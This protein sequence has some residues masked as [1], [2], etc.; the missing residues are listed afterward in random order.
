[1]RV[2]PRGRAREQLEQRGQGIREASER[3]GHQRAGHQRAGHQRGQWQQRAVSIQQTGGVLLDREGSLL[4]RGVPVTGI[5]QY[6]THPCSSECSSAWH[7][8]R[9]SQDKNNNKKTRD[10][11]TTG[12]PR[13]GPSAAAATSRQRK[14]RGKR[15]KPLPQTKPLSTRQRRSRVHARGPGP[16]C[17][18][19]III[20]GLPAE[21]D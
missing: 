8:Y 3:T 6:R 13:V 14:R 15:G 4:D 18:I 12:A 16:V 7:T 19:H 2:I 21:G 10:R 11:G 1:L 17:M 9:L 20:A 5:G